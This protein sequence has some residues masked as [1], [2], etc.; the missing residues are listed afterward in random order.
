MKV[1]GPSASPCK[2]K[3]QAA[4]CGHFIA[5]LVQTL[6]ERR[7]RQTIERQRYGLKQLSLYPDES[8]GATTTNLRAGKP[9]A[10]SVLSRVSGVYVMGLLCIE[11][12]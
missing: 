3:R 7:F 5:M 2:G 12:I 10:M 9:V 1:G 6:I 4:S 8:G 11:L